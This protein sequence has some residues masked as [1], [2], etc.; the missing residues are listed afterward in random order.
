MA[1]DFTIMKN[2]DDIQ[3]SKTAASSYVTFFK[4]VGLPA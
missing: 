2:E 3:I 4:K 1:I